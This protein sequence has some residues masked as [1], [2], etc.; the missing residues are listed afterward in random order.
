MDK[1][2]SFA[3][4]CGERIQRTPLDHQTISALDFRT[5]SNRGAR[6]V[7]TCDS[8]FHLLSSVQDF[9]TS[10]VGCN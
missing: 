7:K 10:L 1:L 2:W 5:L 8:T 4:C 6:L 9:E 3:S